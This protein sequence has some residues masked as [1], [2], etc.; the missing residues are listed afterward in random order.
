M[1]TIV[2]KEEDLVVDAIAK[3]KGAI[4]AVSKENLDEEG[5]MIEVSAGRG[6]AVS[7]EAIV[8]VEGSLVP[9]KGV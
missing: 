6:F 4:I 5:K 9:N 1:Q 8:A 2:V 7:E 3:N